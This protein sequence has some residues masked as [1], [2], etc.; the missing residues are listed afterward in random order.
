MYLLI[1]E[2]NNIENVFL[3]F[4]K[5]CSVFRICYYY[6]CFFNCV[7][8]CNNFMW[9]WWI[10]IVFGVDLEMGIWVSKMV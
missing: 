5:L 2:S 7:Y 6:N 10:S 3:F 9:I 1:E 4:W 8:V